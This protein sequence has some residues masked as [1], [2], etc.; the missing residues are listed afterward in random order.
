MAAGQ[1]DAAP[2]ARTAVVIDMSD[3]DFARIHEIHLSQGPAAAVDELVRTL[4]EQHDWPAHAAFMDALFEEGFA[5]LVGPL[6]G[7]TDAL[8]ILRAKDADEIRARLA[9]DPWH[10]QGL[11]RI[12]QIAPWTLRLGSLS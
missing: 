6:E 5:L 12:T 3:S 11:L 8:L 2:A 1:G 9:P 7:T 4:E 10:V